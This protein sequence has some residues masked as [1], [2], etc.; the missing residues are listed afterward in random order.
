MKKLFPKSAKYSS[1]FKIGDKVCM[2]RENDFF[3][4]FKLGEVLTVIGT[5]MG[6]YD[7]CN[8]RGVLQYV[9]ENALRRVNNLTIWNFFIKRED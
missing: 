1:N 8:S 7:C 5:S 4:S 9:S 6:S 2:I 3:C